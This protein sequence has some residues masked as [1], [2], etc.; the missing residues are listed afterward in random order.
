MLKNLMLFLT[1]SS[2]ANN[3]PVERSVPFEGKWE[4][5]DSSP[6]ALPKACLNI[7]DVVKLREIL[8]KCEITKEKDK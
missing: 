3:P 2:C 5:H 8:L 1:L 6:N 7:Q 4:F